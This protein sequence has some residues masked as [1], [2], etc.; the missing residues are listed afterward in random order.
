M[1]TFTIDGYRVQAYANDA[2]GSTTRWADRVIYLYSAG[3]N[4]AIAYFAKEGETAPEPS[5]SGGK[6]WYHANSH[7]YA[8]V[9]DLLR[10]E[11]PVYISWVTKTDSSEAGDGDAYFHTGTEL[12]GEGE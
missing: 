7:M 12:P 8:P 2:A 10:N 6:I 9:I 4:V 1:P 3:Q 11:S 5:Y